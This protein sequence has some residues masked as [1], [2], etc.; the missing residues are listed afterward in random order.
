MTAL[1]VFIRLISFVHDLNPFGSLVN[2]PK[3]FRIQLRFRRDIRIFLETPWYASHRGVVHTAESEFSNIS[4]KSKPNSKILF[5][6][7]LDRFES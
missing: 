6:R 3:Y 4:A 2:G 1:E 5:I 7:G